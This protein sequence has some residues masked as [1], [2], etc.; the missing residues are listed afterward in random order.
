MCLWDI[1]DNLSKMFIVIFVWLEKLKKYI[2]SCTA[3]HQQALV[4]IAFKL[5]QQRNTTV[6]LYLIITH[7][8]LLISD[9]LGN[10]PA[11]IPTGMP[12]NQISGNQTARPGTRTGQAPPRLTTARLQTAAMGRLQTGI[13]GSIGQP[14]LRLPTGIAKLGTARPSTSSAGHSQRVVQD[15]SFWTNELLQFIYNIQQEIH[16][17]ESTPTLSAYASSLPVR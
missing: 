2:S 7:S 14:A 5:H 16:K 11:Q 12:S 15:K 6:R 9:L 4:S 8:Y 3:A 17:L 10:Q 13:A 1:R